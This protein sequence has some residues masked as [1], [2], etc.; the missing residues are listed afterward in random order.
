MIIAAVFP[1]RPARV[2]RFAGALLLR[3]PHLAHDVVPRHRRTG[4]GRRETTDIFAVARDAE[5]LAFGDLVE[6]GTGVVV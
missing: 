5:S 3:G 1:V 6:H 4:L 2:A